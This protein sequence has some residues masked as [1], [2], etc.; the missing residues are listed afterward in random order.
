MTDHPAGRDETADAPSLRAETGDERY[1]TLLANSSEGIWRLEFDPPIDVALPT[2][3][4][5]DLAYRNGVLAECNDAMA[6]MYGLSRADELVGA[7]LDAMLPASDPQARAYVASIVDAGYRVS[8]VES[9]ERDTQGGIRHFSNSMSGVIEGGRLLRIWGT[10]RD[11]TEQKRIQQA[12][13][14]SEARFRFMADAAPVMIWISGQDRDRTWFNAQWLR[15]VGRTLEEVT[16]TR[17]TESVHPEDLARCLDVYGTSFDGRRPFTMEYRLRR[18]DGEYRW[19]L[20]TGVPSYEED[21]VFSGYIGSCVDIS[22]RRRESQASAYL[23]AIVASSDD[24]II[25]K[26]LNGVIQSCNAAAQRLFEYPAE[27]LIGRPIRML[28]PDDRQ[29]EEDL[30][31]AKIRRGERIDHFETIR[32]TKSGRTIDISVTLSPVRDGT[33]AI[34]GVSKVA[35]DI[36]ERKRAAAAIAEQR[37]WFRVTLASIGDAVIS[38]D[39]EGRV[40]FLNPVAERLTAWSAAEGVGQ[41]CRDVVHLIREPGRQAIDDPVAMV[42]GRGSSV[43]LV[44]QTLLVARDGTER[45]IDA[46]GAPIRDYNGDVA[47][48]VLVFR[49]VSEQRR[50]EMERDA[51]AADRER[52]LEAERAARTAAERASRVKD[53]FVAMVSHELRTPLNAILGWVELITRGR[54]DPAVVDR[55]LDIISRN[56][57]AQAQLISDLLDI[58]RIVSGKLQLDVQPLDLRAVVADAI[59]TVE[60]EAAAK[61]ITIEKSLTGV[62]AD[63]EGDPARL[64]Q[65]I[66]NLLS[67]AIKFTPKGG[68]VSVSLTVAAETV[69]VTVSDTG[70]GIKGDVLPHVFDRFHQADRSI[71]RRFGGLGLG[72]AI[73]KHLVELHGGTVHAESPGLGA[74]AR[75][76]FRLP[77]IRVPK[78]DNPRARDSEVADERET[79]SLEGLRVLLV[80]DEPDT[81]EYLLRLLEDHGATVFAVGAAADALRIFRDQPVDILISDIGLPE[82]DGYD[83]VRQIR[84]ERPDAECPAIAL[85]AYAR[86]QDQARALHAGYSTHI[87]KPTEPAELLAAI[88][89]LTA[90]GRPARQ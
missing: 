82:M 49:D 38:T 73:V 51:V 18:H 10:Q 37:E 65:V 14:E 55:G 30:F 6:R 84:R 88:A 13:R 27:E 41:H 62:R 86:T 63:V 76:A 12:L 43:D 64:Q 75:F 21:L 31:L 15:F 17:W 78:A 47:G 79:V 58:S 54:D 1:L 45:P 60:R 26:D 87:A 83:L 8:N 36:T 66:W 44:H 19:L 50:M 67:N 48:A 80:E 81:R 3:A 61:D 20:E 70:A 56:T 22:D 28:I 42:L 68:R 4:Q 39:V 35:R 46:G 7:T 90:P 24:A 69:E 32:R 77:L 53:E 72:L 33:G 40:V 25:A 52:L 11:I 23:A 57:R 29:H 9:V 2:G 71:T 5:V 85:T 59:E 89:I 74:G 34:V 16:G